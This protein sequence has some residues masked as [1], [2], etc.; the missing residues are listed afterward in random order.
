MYVGIYRF[1]ILTSTLVHRDIS[2]ITLD[3]EILQ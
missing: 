1:A 2:A 3:A